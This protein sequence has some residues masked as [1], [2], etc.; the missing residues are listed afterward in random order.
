MIRISLSRNLFAIKFTKMLENDIVIANIDEWIVN[1]KSGDSYSWGKRGISTELKSLPFE[2]SMSILL[3]IFS[4]G[5]YFWSIIQSRVNSSIFS[6]YLKMMSDWI[7]NKKVFEERRIVYILDNCP[8]HRA[9]ATK[10]VMKALN[11]NYLFLSSYSPQL[12]PVEL[13]FNTFK[14]R[15]NSEWKGTITNLNNIE[16]FEKIG[17]AI[18]L[19]AGE[20]IRKY[21]SIFLRQL[22]FYL[23]N[24]IE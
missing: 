20:E 15:L 14:Q 2:G 5:A 6:Q 23:H 17:K 16:S 13:S 10:Q 12:A 8:S 21:F 9:N 24:S 19:F 18:K 1:Y 11:L 22:K 7:N 4:T 3:W